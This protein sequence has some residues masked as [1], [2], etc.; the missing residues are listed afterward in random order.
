LQDA[1]DGIPCDVTEPPAIGIPVLL[2]AV[3]LPRKVALLFVPLD[4][5]AKER[6]EAAGIC[7]NL[8]LTCRSVHHADM[9]WGYDLPLSYNL[10]SYLPFHP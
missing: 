1:V 2:G 4:S 7:P 9:L 10:G 5:D 8:E 3:E 6:M